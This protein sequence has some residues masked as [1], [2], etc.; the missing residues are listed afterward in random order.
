MQKDFF[1]WHGIKSS[2]QDRR[3]HVWYRAQEVW[4]CSFGVNVGREQDGKGEKFYRPVLVF[5]KFKTQMFWA[6]PITSHQKIGIFYHQFVLHNI[7]E[8][9]ILSQLRIL[10]EK[11]LVRRLGKISDREFLRLNIAFLSLLNETD[12]LKGSSGA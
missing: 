5:R 9:A 6:I 1:I 4:W 3:D 8:T 12:P 7:R 10:S 11:R 2:I